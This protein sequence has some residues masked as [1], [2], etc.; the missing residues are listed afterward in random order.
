MC[1]CGGGGGWEGTC[2]SLLETYSYTAVI[3]TEHAL[4]MYVP[5][6]SIFY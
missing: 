4:L 3:D 6:L 5:V 2:I 1:V